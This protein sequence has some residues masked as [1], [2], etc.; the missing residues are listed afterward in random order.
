MI[1]VEAYLR[2]LSDESP[3]GEDLEYD[4]A[5]GAMERASQGKP[6]Q[7]YGGTVV[8]AEEPNWAEVRSNAFDLMGRT[9]DLRVAVMLTRAVLGS[10]GFVD[11]SGVLSLIR[12][13]IENYW[14]PLYPR[15]DP[16]DDLDPT[17]RVNLLA[18]LCDSA[19]LLNDLKKTPLVSSRMAGR[20]GLREIA[21]A[22][23]E[24][25]APV[26]MASPPTV[27]M[28]DGAFQDAPLED[29]Q[30]T[31]QAVRT[32][33]EEVGAIESAVTGFVGSGRS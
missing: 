7:Q 31:L 12:G 2:P 4:P 24:V 15:L 14:E 6:E 32:A 8:P 9:K 1:D 18:S 28:I 26:S 11:F 22:K 3:C 5:F 20:F 16:D 33:A 17:I 13:W 29:L 10:G 21:I 30:V 23:G 27:S 19:T 25:P